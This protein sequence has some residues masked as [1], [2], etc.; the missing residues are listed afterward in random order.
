MAESLVQVMPEAPPLRHQQL[1]R[2]FYIDRL[3]SVMTVL[4]ILHHTAITYGAV[5]GWFYNELRPSGAASSRLLTMFCAT[6]QAYFMGFFFLLAGY[7]TPGSLERKGYARFLGDRL[8]RLGLPLLAFIFILGPFTAAM[9]TAYQGKGF[10]STLAYLWNHAIIINGPLWFA[11]ALLMFSAGYCLWRMLARKSFDTA[12][13]PTPV[14]GQGWWL[15]SA[16]AVG[17]CALSIRQVVPSGVNVIGL[18][19]GYFSSYTF[20]FCLGVAAWKCDWLRQLQ[21]RHARPWL[22][23]SL[24]CWPALPIGIVI[25]DR[26]YGPGKAGFGGGHAWPALLYALWEPF[27]AWGLITA[28][29]L[30]FRQF[31]YHPSPFW[32][33]LN[34]RAYAVY[35]IHPPLLVGISLLLHTWNAPAGLKFVVTGALACIAC[36]LVADPLV[37]LP[38]LRRVV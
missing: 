18:Q 28:W 30:A 9:V 37:R 7:F 10:W 25:A 16:F 20:L 26:V 27:V 31:M 15:F 17:L 19:L 38:G 13:V 23:V 24:I 36:W 3:R 34:R 6:N 11:Q 4:V 21:W 32:T 29:L 12:R 8:L 14:P 33:W 35:I 22:I 1:A 2:E 5:G